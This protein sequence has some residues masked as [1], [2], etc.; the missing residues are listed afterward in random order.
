M[1]HFKLS[2]LR[3]PWHCPPQTSFLLKPWYPP[4]PELSLLEPPSL[5]C[6]LAQAPPLHPSLRPSPGTFQLST[7][8][9]PSFQSCSEFTHLIVTF[10]LSCGFGQKPHPSASLC[11]GCHLLTDLSISGG[12]KPKNPLLN[13]ALAKRRHQSSLQYTVSGKI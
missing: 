6:S 13:P 3:H 12:R 4:S 9:S 5:P 7:V 8:S 1:N 2:P 10:M 11:G